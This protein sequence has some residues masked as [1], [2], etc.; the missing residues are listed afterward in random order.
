MEQRQRRRG[1]KGEG[2]EK[3]KHNIIYYIILYK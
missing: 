1:E 3:M 2:G